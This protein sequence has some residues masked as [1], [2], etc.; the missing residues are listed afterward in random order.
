MS[1]AIRGLM[2]V[3]TSVCLGLAVNGA[4]AQ[5]PTFNAS[6]GGELN[7]SD[8]INQAPAALAQSEF[9]LNLTPT[10]GVNYRSGRSQL[11]GFAGFT[12]YHYLSGGQSDTIYPNIGLIGSLEAIEQFLFIDASVTASPQFLNPFRP[13]S[14]GQVTNNTYSAYNYQIAPTIKG[15]IFGDA[16]YQLRSN[17]SWST[18][19]T[20]TALGNSSALDNSYQWNLDGSVTRAPQPFGWALQAQHN[21]VTQD[22]N[23]PSYT[24]D[25]ARGSV[26]YRVAED[27]SLSARGGYEQADIGLRSTTNVIYGGGLTWRPTPRTNLDGYWERR[28]FG[29]SWVVSASHR[30]PFLALN[31]DTSRDVVSTPDTLFT[32]PGGTNI[33]NSLDAILTTRIPDA[34]ARAAAARQIML[35][36]GLPAQLAQPVPIYSQNISLQ[37]RYSGAVTLYGA[38]NSLA[39]NVYYLR[40]E[41]VSGTGF[42]LPPALALFQNSVQRGASIAASHSLTPFTSLSAVALWQQ[43][44]GVGSQSSDES[45]QL[46]YRLQLNQQLAARLT[47]YVGLRYETYTANVALDYNETAA[48]IGLVYT[49]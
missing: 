26:S 18:S 22:G 11:N 35:V 1:R 3:G 34:S 13:Q 39:F 49:F 42:N 21:T 30:M 17:S 25:L 36:G 44:R 48:L 2:W 33:F 4:R 8:N 16:T 9:S 27:F 38:R 31:L 12:A 6:L 10:L 24:N 43:T 23:Q 15:Q 41:A 40:S 45:R 28:Y 47:G 14:T 20:G 37:T 7:W 46:T 32:V 29:D 19:G 5:T